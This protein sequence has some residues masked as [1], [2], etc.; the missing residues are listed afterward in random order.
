MAG[1]RLAVATHGRR[2]ECGRLSDTARQTVHGRECPATADSSRGRANDTADRAGRHRPASQGSPGVRR[3]EKTAGME[4]P[5]RQR[6]SAKRLW[7]QDQAG[8]RRKRRTAAWSFDLVCPAID[9]LGSQMVLPAFPRRQS[10]PRSRY[11][12]VMNM[13]QKTDS[14]TGFAPHR[15]AGRI[16]P[17]NFN[18][19]DPVTKE[20]E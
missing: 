4:K 20:A 6:R 5:P 13:L 12:F 3:P 19:H 8:G 11:P 17:D 18:H 16:L 2:A 15:Q 7:N 1:R 9:P 10:L 14:D